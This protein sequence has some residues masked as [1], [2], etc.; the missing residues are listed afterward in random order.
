[1]ASRRLTRYY[2]DMYDIQATVQTHSRPWRSPKRGQSLSLAACLLAGMTSALELDL[3]MP[4][5]AAE[6][7]E[8][9]TAAAHAT[10]AELRQRFH[11]PLP[12]RVSIELAAPGRFAA[13]LPNGE[14]VRY[15]GLAA[16]GHQYVAVDLALVGRG[17]LKLP[18]VLRH[19]LFHV[20]AGTLQLPRWFDEGMAM[21]FAGSLFPV[22]ASE[23]PV[24]PQLTALSEL[25]AG[26]TAPD[27][28]TIREAYTE[29]YLFTRHLLERLGEPAA[30]RFLEHRRTEPAA[31]FYRQFRGVTGYDLEALH[32]EFRLPYTRTRPPLWSLVKRVPLFAWLAMILVA[33]GILKWRR[34]KNKDEG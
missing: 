18:E 25:E 30:V 3:K 19:E 33:G 6:H 4:E 23:P 17:T 29:A 12:T 20:A 11:L 22:D 8:T 34:L 24:R 14:L 28:R 7:A 2:S 13:L 15:D 1:M 31:D 26:F 27:A 5:A 21:I 10:D 32:R 9:V 16:A